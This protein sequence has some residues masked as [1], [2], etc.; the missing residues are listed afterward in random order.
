MMNSA[1]SCTIVSLLCLF[2]AF[3]TGSFGLIQKQ[4]T[5]CM[6]TG[7]MYMLSGEYRLC[8]Q[9][10]RPVEQKADTKETSAVST[11]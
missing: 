2:T 1:A 11:V 8:G 6:V 5:A 3:V 10:K 4:V 7:V 9:W